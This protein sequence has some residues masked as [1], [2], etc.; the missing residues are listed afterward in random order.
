ME[1]ILESV[2][3]GFLRLIK[4]IVLNV[5]VDIFIHGI[6]YVALKLVTFG[7]YP[8]PNQDNATLC[9]SSG[10]GVLIFIIAVIAVL[11]SK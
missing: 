7:K 6:G 5:V 2:A 3:R 11:N 10:V 1:D 4:A 8:K 9:I